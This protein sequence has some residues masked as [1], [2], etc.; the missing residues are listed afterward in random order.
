VPPTGL[1]VVRGLDSGS[2][3]LADRYD[4]ICARYIDMSYSVLDEDKDGQLNLV[5]DDWNVVRE[6]LP[7]RPFR[8]DDPERL[9]EQRARRRPPKERRDR[10]PLSTLPRRAKSR[11]AGSPVG[12]ALRAVRHPVSTFKPP[13][14]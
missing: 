7:A 1:A 13:P 5:P 10:K 12:P 14:R 6:L 3:V 11:L 8:S 2:T 9:R 4:E